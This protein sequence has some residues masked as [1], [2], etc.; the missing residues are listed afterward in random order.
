MRPDGIFASFESSDGTLSHP[1]PAVEKLSGKLLGLLSDFVQIFRVNYPLV[2]TESFI[3]RVQGSRFGQ[4][5]QIGPTRPASGCLFA[6]EVKFT[7][8]NVPTHQQADGF[9]GAGYT[10]G[11]AKTWIRLWTESD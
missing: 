1:G 3:R 7:R 6:D 5:R 2:L 4:H 9:A 11:G 10:V 8:D